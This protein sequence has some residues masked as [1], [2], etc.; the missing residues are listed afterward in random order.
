MKLQLRVALL[1]TL[2]LCLFVRPPFVKHPE[3]YI[4]LLK[5]RYGW[6]LELKDIKKIAEDVLQTEREFNKKAGVS[7]EFWSFPEFMREEPLPPNDTVFDI[8]PEEIKRIWDVKIP[9]DEF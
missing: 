4:S 6:Q 5:G 9:I 3:F 8:S 7:E 1:D 2:G